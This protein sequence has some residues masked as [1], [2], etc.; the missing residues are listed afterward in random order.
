MAIY[1]IADLEKLT[2]IKAHTIRIWEKRFGIINPKRTATNIRYYDD[3]DLKKITNISLLNKEGYKISAISNMPENAIEDLIANLTEVESFNSD[4]LDALTLSVIHLDEIKFLH[5]VNRNIHQLGFDSTFEQLLM[6]LLDKLHEMWLS[7]SIKKVH[8][9]F[10]L[11]LIKRKIT[12]E[13]ILFENPTR[14]NHLKFLLT[15]PEDENQELSRLFVEY[16]LRKKGIQ[17]LYLSNESD[18]KD[19]MDA[20]LIFK[21]HFIITFI[22]EDTSLT[23][24]T[25]LVQ[26]IQHL[27]ESPVLLVIGYLANQLSSY[28]KHVRV[29]KDFDDLNQFIETIIHFS[30]KSQVN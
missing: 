24:A 27:P 23:Y 17:L 21:A 18:I 16:I 22:N 19:V 3:Y 10:A 5:I 29:I 8:E 13:I 25:D 26:A 1:S 30:E 7:G 15:M 2:G 9:E 6:P 11:Q 4:S 12:Q 28:E 14:P 20:S